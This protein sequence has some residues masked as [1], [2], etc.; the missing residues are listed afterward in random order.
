M[1]SAE[2]VEFFGDLINSL[3]QQGLGWVLRQVVPNSD[4]MDDTE[5]DAVLL[6]SQ[7]AGV[8]IQQ[9]LNALELTLVGTVEMEKQ[10]REFFSEYV[11]RGDMRVI[12]VPDGETRFDIDQ[13]GSQA[14]IEASER[15]RGIINDLRGVIG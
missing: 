7:M 6:D 8:N 5:V 9:V 11:D 14:R 12:D 2:L 13:L 10:I 1:D 4:E 15:I 3:R